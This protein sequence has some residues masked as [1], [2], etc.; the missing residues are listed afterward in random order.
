MNVS[1]KLRWFILDKS[2]PARRTRQRVK[3]AF[4]VILFIALFWVIP[5]ERVFRAM[6]SASL[7]LLL[8]GVIVQIPSTFLNALELKLIINNQGLTLSAIQVWIINL[9]IKFYTLFMQGTLAASGIRWYKFSQKDNKPAEALASVAFY[10]LLGTFLSIAMGLAFWALNSNKPFRMNALL[11]FGLLIAITVFWIGITRLSLPLLS[12][13]NQHF[14]QIIERPGWKTL[15]DITEK[16]LLAVAAF[17]DFSGWE[18]FQ[19]ILVGI[20]QQLVSALSNY[21]FA[22]SIGITL[23]LKDIIWISS[24]VVLVSQLPIAIAGGFGVREASLVA[25]M[26]SF[27]V[28]GEQA[29][30]YS[31]LLFFRNVFLSLVG[32]LLELFQTLLDKRDGK[33]ENK[34]VE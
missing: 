19:V 12:W 34:S 5:I 33:S 3:I 31:F 4:L 11:L 17:K 20:C 15:H 28:S 10:R 8:I 16:M 7:S 24:V 2:A 1:A 23:P 32:G 18:L 30:A 22:L 29:L 6:I 9:E 21:F 13:I 14:A 27:G 25:L 26:A